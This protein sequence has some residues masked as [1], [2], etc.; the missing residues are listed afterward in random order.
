MKGEYI[1]KLKMKISILILAF[2]LLVS[3]PSFAQI[4][5]PGVQVQIKLNGVEVLSPF[6]HLANSTTYVDVEV[7]ARLVNATYEYNPQ[8]KV[9]TVNGKIMENA[10]LVEGVPTVAIRPLVD[11]TGGYYTIE[12]EGS[13]RTVHILDLPKGVEHLN[14]HAEDM[15]ELW[16][17]PSDLP[18]GPIFGVDQDFFIEGKSMDDLDGFRG[19]PTPAVNHVRFNYMKEGQPG[20]SK[21]HYNIHIFFVSNEKRKQLNIIDRITKFNTLLALGDSIPFGYGLEATNDFYSI[22]AYPHLVQGGFKYLTNSQ[23]TLSGTNTAHMLNEL[24]TPEHIVALKKATVITLTIGS[25]D[26]LGPAQTFLDKYLS[27]SSYVASTQEQ[28]L[29]SDGAA[30]FTENLPLILSEIRKH[31]NANIIVYNLYNPFLLLAS[32]PVLETLY[33]LAETYIPAM[34]DTINNTIQRLNDPTIV[35]VDAYSAFEN[36]QLQFV[37]ILQQDIHPT[38]AGQREL[39]KLADEAIASWK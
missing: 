34:N 9:A 8:T 35:V 4:T 20:L 12:W 1:I 38:L 32:I 5:I 30:Q 25:N 3:S 15:V 21:A 26:V 27:N 17:K 37:R 39:A 29:L 13:T 24:K 19:K 16:A 31:S 2:S 33:H 18:K 14:P 7:Y 11:A 36:K 23:F 6:N 28:Q 22:K 10:R